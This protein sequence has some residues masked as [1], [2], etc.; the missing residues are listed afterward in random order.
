MPLIQTFRLACLAAVV[1]GLLAVTPVAGDEVRA[2]DR[3][4]AQ[5]PATQL[6]DVVVV[7]RRSDAPIWQI[8]QGSSTLILVGAI[9][10]TPRDLA[11]RP[12]GLQAATARA[13]RVLFPQEARISPMDVFRLIWRIRSIGMMPEG[14]TTADYLVPE[15]QSRLDAQMADEEDQ[16][17]R[18]MSLLITAY[19]LMSDR[20]GL[21]QRGDNDATDVVRRA[22]RRHRI[23]VTPVGTVRGDELIDSLINAPQSH[24]VPCV[25]TAIAAAEQGQDGAARRARDWAARR[26]PDVLASPVDEALFLCWPWGDP[27]VAPELR[28]QWQAAAVRELGRPGVTLA[29]VPLRVLAERDGVL[30][31]LEAQ[32]LDIIGPDWRAPE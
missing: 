12:E 23:P 24:H 22:A 8:E 9:R 31:R 14:R 27:Q 10:G 1:G 30:D 7:A 4:G 19:S 11:W 20:T 17:W 32:G 3:A 25:Q 26:V 16:D 21:D 18:R 29:V 13:D 5:D 6:D 28:G 15:W 2:Q